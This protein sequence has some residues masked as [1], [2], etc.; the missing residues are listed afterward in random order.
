VTSAGRLTKELYRFNLTCFMF[1]YSKFAST[2]VT[3]GW[4]KLQSEIETMDLCVMLRHAA[5]SLLGISALQWIWCARFPVCVRR[6]VFTAFNSRNYELRFNWNTL[7]KQN[8]CK[9]A[10]STERPPFFPVVT[11]ISNYTD[12]I[13]GWRHNG[14]HTYTAP[15]SRYLGK[16]LHEY[17]RYSNCYSTT[18]DSKTRRNSVSCH[19]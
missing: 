4:R 11:Q 13:Q 2:K 18:M 19:P 7:N 10:A 8:M 5:T 14:V 17:I 16:I 15:Q 9:E 12:P 3:R 6:V 1:L